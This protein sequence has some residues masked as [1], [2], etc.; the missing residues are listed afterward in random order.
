MPGQE[1]LDLIIIGA[2]A[3]GMAAGIYGVR[4][5]LSTLILE[6]GIAG[7]QTNLSPDIPNYPGFPHISGMELTEKIKQHTLEYAEIKEGV[8][9]KSIEVK[10][11]HYVLDT[12]SGKLIAHALILATGARHRRLGVPGEESLTGRGVSYCAT[13]DGFFFKGKK[14]LMIGGGNTAATEALY[15]KSVGVDVAMVHRRD[16]LRAEKRFCQ[17][18]KEEGIEVIWDTVLV[19]IAGDQQV[20]AVKLK[21]VKTGETFETPVDGVFIAVGVE[22]NN[23]LAKALGLEL[24]ETGYVVTDNSMRTNL[25]RVYAAGDLRGGLKQV[26]TSVSEG[27]IAAVSTF[28]DIDDPYWKAKDQQAGAGWD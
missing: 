8:E 3:G 6:K 9:V 10:R 4:S 23:Q 26:V 15:L 11:D 1:H 28:E 7:G 25:E 24:D 5:G 21:N 16:E 20:E 14:A 13:C 27:A 2:G 18:L 19:E 12:S 22:P 17:R